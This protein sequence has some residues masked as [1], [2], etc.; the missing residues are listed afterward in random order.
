MAQ[1][2]INRYMLGCKFLFVAIIVISNYE[3]IDTCWDVN[4]E[5]NHDEIQLSEN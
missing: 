5:Y 1:Q 4:E 3:L 2:R